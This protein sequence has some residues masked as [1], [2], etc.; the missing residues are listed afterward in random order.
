MKEE[1]KT[2]APPVIKKS[3][4][5]EGFSCLKIVLLNK[6]SAIVHFQSIIATAKCRVSKIRNGNFTGG[7]II[8]MIEICSIF[9]RIQ[10][11]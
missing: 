1:N 4:R 11:N 5:L 2:P 10:K 8:C 9:I 7:L 3:L 6:L